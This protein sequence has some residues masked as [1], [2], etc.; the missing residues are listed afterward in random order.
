MTHKN[1]TQKYPVDTTSQNE[2]C[3]LRQLKFRLEKDTISGGPKQDFL[4]L[5]TTPHPPTIKATPKKK[6]NKAM[7]S[8]PHP[9]PHWFST[10]SL[11]HY[12]HQLIGRTFRYYI[13][14]WLKPEREKSNF[15]F[16]QRSH[17]V[18]LHQEQKEKLIF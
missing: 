12:V 16:I 10:Q 13:S 9:P 18:Q 5:S 8:A 4:P 1:K 14:T 2:S 17:F 15:R 11:L 7:L 3:L 6:S